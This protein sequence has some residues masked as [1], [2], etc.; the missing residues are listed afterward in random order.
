MRDPY[1]NHA[2]FGKQTK[3][4]NIRF[5][6]QTY[7]NYLVRNTEQNERKHSKEKHMKTHFFNT[8]EIQHINICVKY[9]FY[10]SKAKTY[11]KMFLKINSELI[12]EASSK[13]QT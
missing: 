5:K 1:N 12:G 2:I 3:N 10:S 4:S 8:L 7:I 6:N 13:L 9:F 11:L